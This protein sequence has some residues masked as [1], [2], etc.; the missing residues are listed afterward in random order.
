MSRSAQKIILDR[1]IILHP[2]DSKTN[3]FIPFSLRK[4]YSSLEFVYS[5]EPKNCEDREK[6]RELLLKGMETYVPAEY[7]GRLGSFGSPGFIEDFLPSVVNLLTLSLDAPGRYLGC[8]HRHAPEQR[9]TV[10]AEFSSPGFFRHPPT[11][12][13]WRVLINVH[14][15][16]SR[17]LRCRLKILAYKDKGGG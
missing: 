6:A 16:V 2:E 5:Y 12:G 4:D 1:T 14:A 11:A 3:V 8:A 15:V 10:S 13:D 9:H 7:R 17:E